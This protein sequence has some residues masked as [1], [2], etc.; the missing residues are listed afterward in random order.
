M[1]SHK[2]IWNNFTKFVLWGTIAVITILVLWLYFSFINE[3]RFNK[4]NRDIEQRIAI[5][6]EVIKKY[7]SIG[8]EVCLSKNYG[9][10][11]GINDEIYRNEGAKILK[12]EKKFFSF[13]RA[14]LQ[15]NIL[16]D[17]NLNKLK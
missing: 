16:N 3:N 14:I 11:L 2:K 12:S 10:H 6:P 8:L 9:S 1:R 7:K 13:R 17:T 4:E 15:M 5:T